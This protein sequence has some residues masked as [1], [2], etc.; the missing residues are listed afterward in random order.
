MGVRCLAR[1][2]SPASDYRLCSP[3]H[4]NELKTPFNLEFTSQLVLLI[5]LSY[6]RSRVVVATELESLCRGPCLISVTVRYCIHVPFL[7]RLQPTG[8][9][10]QQNFATVYS[11]SSLPGTDATLASCCSILPATD[12]KPAPTAPT[13][14]VP[15][16][17]APTALGT[18][19]HGEPEALPA[20]DCPPAA[21]IIP[22][23]SVIEHL[24]PS[25]PRPYDRW[26]CPCVEFVQL[27]HR[28]HHFVILKVALPSVRNDGST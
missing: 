16:T 15:R 14:R 28:R 3:R 18:I 24:D 5:L 2:T 9:V 12:F 10:R 4:S 25:A 22:A 6:K 11:F 20:L 1:L 19:S 8:M 26:L 23:L 13:T 27:V 17:S 21:L 7:T